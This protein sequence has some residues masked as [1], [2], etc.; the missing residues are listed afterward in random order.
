MAGIYELIDDVLFKHNTLQYSTSIIGYQN[1]LHIWRSTKQSSMDVTLW[2]FTMC[3]VA[4]HYFD[5]LIKIQVESSASAIDTFV[6]YYEPVRTSFYKQTDFIMGQK[7]QWWKPV[8]SLHSI[9][10][11]SQQCLHTL[12]MDFTA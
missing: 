7:I 1:R 5:Q 2:M 9:K 4:L 11:F 12:E 8:L 6:E 3:C 10:L